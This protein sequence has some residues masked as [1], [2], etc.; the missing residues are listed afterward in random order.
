MFSPTT[1]HSRVSSRS[2]EVPKK[3]WPIV[4]VLELTVTHR[5]DGWEVTFARIDPQL[6]TRPRCGGSTPTGW[7]LPRQ[8]GRTEWL[9]R[10]KG[11]R[12]RHQDMFEKMM[13]EGGGR[14]R[15]EREL[16][17]FRCQNK[18]QAAGKSGLRSGDT[19]SRRLFG[20]HSRTI[21]L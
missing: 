9:V 16:T 5:R 20:S 15:G 6:N 3:H 11:R 13:V 8:D 4:R 2:S 18:M 19:I 10:Q 21:Q 7:M 1:E 17:S 12:R 14:E